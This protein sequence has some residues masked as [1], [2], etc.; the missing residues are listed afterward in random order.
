M[1]DEKRPS[2]RQGPRCRDGSRE[3]VGAPTRRID[4]AHV[5]QQGADGLHFA[6]LGSF[7]SDALCV[8]NFFGRK[9]TS[10]REER[11]HQSGGSRTNGCFRSGTHRA[12]LAGTNRRGVGLV[13]VSGCLNWVSGRTS[14]S[15]GHVREGRRGYACVE[16]VKSVP[17]F[18]SSILKALTTFR[19]RDKGS[20]P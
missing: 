19:F 14:R 4:D 18:R 2:R 11:S 3:S 12:L 9:T 10:R 20:L 5:E 16:L 7:A 6:S 8:I 15:R 17:G 13:T 1:I